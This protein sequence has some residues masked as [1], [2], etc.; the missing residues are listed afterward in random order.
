VTEQ[1]EIYV[2]R[3]SQTGS[4][5]I[6]FSEN[7]TRRIKSLQTSSPE[8]LE[9]VCVALGSLEEEKS[10]HAKLSRHR[11]KGE[12]YQPHTEIDQVILDL[13]SRDGHFCREEES[14]DE[15][16]SNIRE[17]LIYITNTNRII[18]GWGVQESIRAISRKTGIARGA[19]ES[20]LRGRMKNATV[21]IYMAITSEY[22]ATLTAEIQFYT[23]NLKAARL[24]KRD[25]APTRAALETA[26]AQANELM[27]RE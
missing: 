9:V 15:H 18:Y 11:I 2:V 4:F 21:L 17:K 25:C 13:G 19:F 1:G 27:G 8:K 24:A 23:E 16:T 3:G 26:M 6:G 5:K 12:W 14:Q 7:A 22:V 20:I 10:L